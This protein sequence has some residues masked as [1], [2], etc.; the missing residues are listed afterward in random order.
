VH[1]ETNAPL[2]HALGEQQQSC[3]NWNVNI[4]Q[5]NK[6][7]AEGFGQVHH[8]GNKLNINFCNWLDEHKFITSKH[9]HDI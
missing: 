4:S 8:R 7:L 2:C 5:K 1:V 3:W 9:R 6:Q